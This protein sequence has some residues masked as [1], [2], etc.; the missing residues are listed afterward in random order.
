VEEKLILLK[1]YAHSKR[2]PHTVNHL[3]HSNYN[4]SKQLKRHTRDQHEQTAVQRK[5]EMLALSIAKAEEII[6]SD[7]KRIDDE[8]KKLLNGQILFA[9]SALARLMKA[10]QVRQ[11]SMHERTQHQVT[12]NMVSLF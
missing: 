8:K 4:I 7:K 2:L 11:Y 3:N 5:Y 10:I 6:Q 9:S 1:D 12:H